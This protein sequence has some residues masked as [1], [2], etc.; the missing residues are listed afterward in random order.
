MATMSNV[1]R[2]DIQKVLVDFVEV[3]DK[4]TSL[5]VGSESY[6]KNVLRSALGSDI[7]EGLINRI[8]Q[9][10][11]NT[12]GLDTLKWMDARSV[13]QVIRDEHPQV[14]AIILTYLDYEQA[15][16]VLGNFPL[17]S[18]WIND[19]HGEPRFGR[20]CGAAGIKYHYGEVFCWKS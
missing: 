17:N 4:Q 9:E 19:T 18:V 7:A 1:S 6:I 3:A 10:S 14:V 8:F 16:Q 2:D 12:L 15:A 5:G 11:K 13:A 20:T